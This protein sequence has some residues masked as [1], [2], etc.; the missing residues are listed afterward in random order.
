MIRG[1]PVIQV[2][3]LRAP[4]ILFRLL[5]PY[6]THGKVG[7]PGTRMEARVSGNKIAL[8]AEGELLEENQAIGMDPADGSP[9]AFRVR[10]VVIGIGFHWERKEDQ[11]FTGA[12]RLSFRDGMI[13]LVNVVPAEEYLN[14][15]ISSEMRASGPPELLRAHAVISR[16][17]LLFHLGKKAGKPVPVIEEDPGDITPGEHIRWYDR[18]EHEGFHVCAD[19]HCQ[20]YQGFTRAWDPGVRKAVSDTAG[21]VLV[22]RGELCDARFSKC[23]GGVTERFESCWEP[24]VH[25]YLVSVSDNADNGGR[26]PD[27]TGEAEAARFIKGNPAAFCNTRDRDLLGRVLNEYDLPGMGNF[28]W[29]VHYSQEELAA[30]V[31][32]RSGI[33]FGPVTDLEPLERGTSGR[34]IRLRISGEKRILIVGKELEIRKWLSQTHLF[35]SAFTVEKGRVEGGVPV[36]FTLYGAGWGHGVGL[37]QIGAAVMASSGYSYREILQHYY[38]GASV[39]K[40]YG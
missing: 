35:S 8:Y 1:E 20:R 19:D 12:I 30:L 40:R 31:R 7:G 5:A 2:G 27:L 28:R 15:V 14:G 22:Y 38:K 29:K 10:D 25:P 39:E 23:C 26:L 36:S 17:W 3:I 32:E 33:D 13:Q 37:C 6:T 34:I 11:Q 21:E 16:S 4:V 9:G 24:V 18:E